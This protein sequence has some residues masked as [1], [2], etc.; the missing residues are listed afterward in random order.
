MFTRIRWRMV[1]WSMLVLGLVLVVLGTVVYLLLSNGLMD[2][3]DRNLTSRAEEIGASDREFGEH[4]TRLGHEGYS[5]GLF[6]L[7]VDTTGR[8]LADPQGVSLASLGFPENLPSGDA[9]V[10]KTITL[11]GDPTRLY[12]RQRLDQRS[13]PTI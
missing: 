11:D 10:Y 7:A 4:A 12:L 1:G 8:V 5:G 6:Y 2:E 13:G 9:P 3:V